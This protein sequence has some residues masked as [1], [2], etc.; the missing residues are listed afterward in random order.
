[1]LV[2]Y[3]KDEMSQ[4]D[5]QMVMQGNNR[6]FTRIV[7][8]HELIPGHHLQALSSARHRP[9]RS[10]FSTPFYVE[11]WP[12]Y[13]EMR[14]WDLDYGQTPEDRIGMLFWRM[15]RSARIIVSLKFHLGR[16][17]PEEMVK[18]LVERVGHEKFGATSEVRRFI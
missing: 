11:G 8:A 2:A 7:T 14:L 18:F 3:A 1:M 6:H 12:L 17:K 10:A 4:E 13:W 15:H 5:K 16:I 9:Y